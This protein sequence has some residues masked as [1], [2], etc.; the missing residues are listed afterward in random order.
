MWGARVLATRIRVPSAQALALLRSSPRLGET[1]IMINGELVY[2][3]TQYTLPVPRL[4]SRVVIGIEVSQVQDL[5]SPGVQITLQNKNSDE[6]TEAAW[7]D[8]VTVGG[9]DNQSY[10]LKGTT[11]EELV[12]LKVAV[13]GAIGKV[14]MARVF[15]YEPVWENY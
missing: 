3:G 6:N 13:T 5:A 7:A 2:S 8:V 11:I 14:G 9:T 10:S 15:V 12:R 1:A 4:G